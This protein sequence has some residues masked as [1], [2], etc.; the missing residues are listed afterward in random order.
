MA[1]CHRPFLVLCQLALLVQLAFNQSVSQLKAG[2]GT[3]CNCSCV[4]INSNF[5]DGVGNLLTILELVEVS[6]GVC[7]FSLCTQDSSPACI[8][9]I[10]KQ[11]NAYGLGTETVLVILVVPD[12]GYINGDRLGLHSFGIQH[13]ENLA[14]GI[15]FCNGEF[16]QC[17]A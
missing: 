1:C 9:P 8:F 2:L 13:A 7:P 5:L 11:L 10:S 6:E 17:V 14:A 4:T 12:L 3:T 15:A 16:A